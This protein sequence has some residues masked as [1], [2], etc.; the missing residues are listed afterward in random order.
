MM[1]ILLTIVFNKNKH[2]SNE[3]VL[4]YKDKL[5]ESGLTPR[6]IQQLKF[7]SLTGSQ[8]DKKAENYKNLKSI[9][10]PYFTIEGKINRQFSR[11]RYLEKPKI[12]GDNVSKSFRK[13]DQPKNTI[14]CFYLPPIKT[15]WK[16]IAQNPELPILITEG[17]FK[18][19]CACKNGFPTI[20]LGGVY[21]WKS[22]KKGLDKIPDFDLFKWN[23]REVYIVFDSDLLT[24]IQVQRALYDLS[25]VLT[26]LGAHPYI[27]K[28]P[29]VGEEKV[30]LDDFIVANGA[31][32]LESIIEDSDGFELAE[33]L[34]A[35][36]QEVIL[37]SNMSMILQRSN[38]LLLRPSTFSEVNYAD[39]QF[40]DTRGDKVAVKQVAKEWLKW[41]LRA[42]VTDIVYEPGIKG[43]TEDGKYSIWDG[44]GC[45]PKKGNIKPWTDML[46]YVFQKDKK[47]RAWFEKWCAIQVQKPGV[48]LHSAVVFWSR[49]QGTGKSL[50]G[51][52][53]LKLFGDNGTMVTWSQ[54]QNTRNDWAEKK[55]FIVGEEMTGSD[56]R[57]MADHIKN[58]ITQEKVTIDQKYVPIYTT[59]DCINYYFTSNHPD[60]F[61]MDDEDR[62]MF[63]WCI[64]RPPMPYDFYI[65]F[66][67]WKNSDGPSALFHYLLQ[68]DLKGF[69]EKTRAME[70]EWK[71]EMID[72]GRSD[73][74]SWVHMI[75]TNPDEVLMNTPAVYNCDLFSAQQLKVLYEKDRGYDNR[76]TGQGMS[77]ALKRAGIP[78]ANGG[79][80]VRSNSGTSKLFIIRNTQKWSV[81][82][83]KDLADH[84][85]RYFGDPTKNEKT[86]KKSKY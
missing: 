70:T 25:S 20:G 31:G 74:A 81:A 63:V 19:A 84:Y 51:E 52:V 22:K 21:S 33:Q 23:G 4:N 73:L 78:K 17:E 26:D 50:I 56:K 60:A 55:Q 8:T 6:D 75:K 41:P 32:A 30:G 18:A 43:T 49:Q 7:K 71:D 77:I 28:L 34:W 54:I 85:N 45:T 64:D 12:F 42:S 66:R 72:T 35:M 24:N 80:Y 5:A 76:I 86:K 59:R 65:K 83:H 67:E 48:K 29:G 13:Y 15:N 9:Y 39:R 3:K 46:D 38:N 36:N 69:D 58:M 27:S 14:P 82:P 57:Q 61:F 16:E 10:I 53:L 37:I 2:M 47:A 62:R 11:I 44:W 1:P 40:L 68:V 79:K